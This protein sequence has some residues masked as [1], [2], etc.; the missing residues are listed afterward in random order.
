MVEM[1][2][3]HGITNCQSE[4]N[5]SINIDDTDTG[6]IATYIDSDIYTEM[7]ILNSSCY[8]LEKRRVWNNSSSHNSVKVFMLILM[9]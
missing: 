8:S 5:V 7:Q 1:C 2:L 4:I 3:I 9:S 6:Y